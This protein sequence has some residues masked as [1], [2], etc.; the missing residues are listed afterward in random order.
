MRHR[1]SGLVL[2]LISPLGHVAVVSVASADGFVFALFGI[3]NLVIG[4]GPL[5]SPRPSCLP[6]LEGALKVTG[7]CSVS[8]YLDR[9]SGE[10]RRPLPDDDGH[11]T[12]PLWH[13]AF[14]V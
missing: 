11:S 8:T 3:I 13:L 9:V 14:C 1:V 12:V 4:S 2:L 10:R 6:R 5:L 7:A